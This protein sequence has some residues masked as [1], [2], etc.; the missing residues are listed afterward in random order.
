MSSPTPTVYLFYG[1]DDL[2]R[3]EFIERLR[4][5][6][7]DRSLADLNTHHSR[8][9]QDDLDQIEQACASIPF[10]A[11]RRMVIIDDPARFLKADPPQRFLR[12]LDLVRSEERRV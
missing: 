12:L 8:A 10:L 1:D 11:P 5:K 6:L 7:G 3:A 9:D 2:A 4:D